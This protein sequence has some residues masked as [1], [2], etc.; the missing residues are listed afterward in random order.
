MFQWLQH[1]VEAPVSAAHTQCQFEIRRQTANLISVANRVEPLSQ[2]MT[3]E[4]TNTQTLMASHSLVEAQNELMRAI[5]DGFASGLS[6]ERVI[7]EGIQ[8]ALD[9]GVVTDLAA[10]SVE[11]TLRRAREWQA[12]RK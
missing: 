11:T 3:L 6:F 12:V 5:V 7:K 1:K 2:E 10:F 4:A 9:A 8:P